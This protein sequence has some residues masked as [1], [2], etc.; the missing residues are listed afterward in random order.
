MRLRYLGRRQVQR[1][2]SQRLRRCFGRVLVGWAADGVREECTS[3]LAVGCGRMC[4]KEGVCF[5]KEIKSRKGQKKDKETTTDPQ[6]G[7]GSPWGSHAG[8]SCQ[9]NEIPWI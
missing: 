2:L 7:T 3:D 9:K 6:G 4:G 8:S 5:R 1:H